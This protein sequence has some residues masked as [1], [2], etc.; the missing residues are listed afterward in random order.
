MRPSTHTGHNDLVTFRSLEVPMYK[1][2]L[3]VTG[4]W[5]Y[6]SFGHWENLMP[7][8]CVKVTNTSFEFAKDR[9]NPQFTTTTVFKNAWERAR[10]YFPPSAKRVRSRYVYKAS[11]HWNFTCLRILEEGSQAEWH[12]VPPFFGE[13]ATV[14]L[15]EF[16]KGMVGQ[17]SGVKSG[18]LSITRTRSLTH[19]AV[20]RGCLR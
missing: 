12:Q 3:R 17:L 9:K 19:T 15:S 4:T 11:M 10:G 5:I 7:T 2:L 20:S 13:T 14:E 18:L 6:L 8:R 16:L 1:G